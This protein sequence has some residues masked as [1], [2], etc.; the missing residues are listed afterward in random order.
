MR[1]FSLSAAELL[2]RLVA[3]GVHLRLVGN[4]LQVKGDLDDELREEIKRNKDCLTQL[5][6]E[7]EHK[8]QPVEEWNYWRDG[9]W[10]EGCRLDSP[11]WT[12]WKI[13]NRQQSR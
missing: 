7:G 3:S 9:H 4:E 8:W 10:I 1:I 6:Q 2:E 13:G 5:V 11:G 12:R